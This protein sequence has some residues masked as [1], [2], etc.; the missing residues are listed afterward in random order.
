MEGFFNQS[1]HVFN[2]LFWAVFTHY[3]E[4]T[5][6]YRTI[7]SEVIVKLPKEISWSDTPEL[8]SS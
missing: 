5:V 4:I 3:H 1:I 8:I 6:Q 7:N 2:E